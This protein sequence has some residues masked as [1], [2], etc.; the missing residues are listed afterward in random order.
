ME[1]IRRLRH[2]RGWSQEELAN[3][4]GC[5]RSSISMIEGGHSLPR[6]ELLK[7]LADAFEVPVCRLFVD[8]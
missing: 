1:T 4:V 3:R 8:V 7:R 5:A 6:K 2:A